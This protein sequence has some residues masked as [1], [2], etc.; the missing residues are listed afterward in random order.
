MAVTKKAPPTPLS[1]PNVQ[2]FSDYVGK[3][4]RITVTFNETTRVLS[5]I[6]VFRDPDCLFT[7]ILIGLGDDG[8]PD[9]STRTVDVPS[10]T[11]VLSNAQLNALKNRGLNTIEEFTAYQITAGRP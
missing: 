6:T 1:S 4:I 8:I 7:R 10:G 9:T 2:E 11:T 3:V 5:G